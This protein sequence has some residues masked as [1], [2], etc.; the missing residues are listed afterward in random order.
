MVKEIE[1]K[2]ISAYWKKTAEHDYETMD[3]LFKIKRYSE[4]LFFGHIVL[5]KIL[6]ALVVQKTEKHA[7]FTHDLVKLLSIAETKF[8]KEDIDFLDEMNT[9]NLQ[10]RYPD[11][12]LGIYKL[13]TKEFTRK[14]IDKLKK[15]YTLL[16]DQLK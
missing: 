7:P 9:Y 8:S 6:K 3:G 16:C 15:V 11:Y 14:R 12:K 13:C 10:T 4:S 5:E 2:K 1:P